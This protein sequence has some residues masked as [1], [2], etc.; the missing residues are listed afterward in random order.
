M[1][2]TPACGESSGVVEANHVE[3]ME[4]SDTEKSD[5]GA[6]NT[7]TTP[8]TQDTEDR[9]QQN[10]TSLDDVIKNKF[11]LRNKILKA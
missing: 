11:R 4:T 10:A 7:S 6:S 2:L 1:Q 5:V 8:S 9:P 3:N